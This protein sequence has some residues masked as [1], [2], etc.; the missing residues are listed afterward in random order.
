MRK[1]TW[2]GVRIHLRLACLCAAYSG[3]SHR[4]GDVQ[5]VTGRPRSRRRL[6]PG[7]TAR[8]WCGGTAIIDAPPRGLAAFDANLPAGTLPDGGRSRSGDRPGM[9]CRT[10]PQVGQGTAKVFR[11]TVEVEDGL[12]STMFGGDNAFAQMIDQTLTI[13]RAGRTT[14]NSRS[15]GATAA[16]PTSGY[17][18]CLRSRCGGCGY[19]FRL[20]TSCYNPSYGS[21]RQARVFIN[22]ARWVRGPSI[23]R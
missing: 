22:E 5:T 6:R 21:E 16:N 10:T 20:E 15:S 13:R 23:R 18:S 14:R 11:Y 1:Q 2:L 12:D 7:S 3:D 4:G 8:D 19:E 17:H 9:W